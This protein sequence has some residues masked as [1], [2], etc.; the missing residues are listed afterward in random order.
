MSVTIPA[1]PDDGYPTPRYAWTLIAFLTI[2]YISSFLDRYILGLL[3]DPIKDSTGATDTQ[4]GFLASA[5]TWIYALAAVPLGFLVD[6]ANRTKLVAIGIAVWSAATVW[7]GTAKSFL[8]LFA[9]RATVGVG[10]AVLSPAAFSMI[11]DSFPKERRGLP[12]AV[13][14]MA[15]VIGAAL[16]NLL[17]AGVLRWARTVGDVTLPLIGS[18]E[19]WQFIFIVVG[20]PGFLI[21]IVFLF[22]REPRRIESSPREGASLGDAFRWIGA[23][24]AAFFTFVP[25]FMCMVAIAYGQFFNAAMFSRTWGWDTSTYALFNGLSILA[26]SPVTYVIAGRLS[27]KRVSAGDRTAPLKLAILGLFIMI[28][29]AAIA[30]ILPTGILAFLMFCTT[31][32]G[33]GLVSATGVNALLAIVPGDVRGVVV[34]IYYFFISFIGGALSPPFIGWLNDA[35]FAGDGLRY[36]MAIYP[37]AFGLPVIV[38]SAFTLRHYRA[39]LLRQDASHA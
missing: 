17:S 37:L 9:A 8:T 6:R 11:G 15:L 5:F 16:A 10:E 36:A 24:A 32:V 1:K 26:I 3:I 31:T 12:I 23:N 22:L 28:P 35:F 38:L 27:D 30:P 18:V 2:A 33:I 20:A 4:M 25:I 7:T 39:A 21:A 19:T 13:Y 34:A 29:S 14:S